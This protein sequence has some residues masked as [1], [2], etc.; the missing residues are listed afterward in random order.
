MLE[1]DFTTIIFQVINFLAL[2]IAL[3]F[4]LFRKIIHRAKVR[5]QELEMIQKSTMDD[6]QNAEKLKMD[7]EL[8]IQNIDARIEESFDKA[9][10]DLEEIRNKVLNDAKEQAEQ[11][12]RQSFESLRMTQ[13]QSKEDFR[14]EIVES[15]ILISKNLLKKISSEE[16]HT[17]LIKEINDRILDLGRKEM[18]RVAVIRESLSERE[19]ILFIETAMP[20][21]KDHQAGIIR[22]FSALADRNVKLD[23]KQVENLICGVRIRLGDY[24]FDNSLLSKLEE[25]GNSTIKELSNSSEI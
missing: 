23:I 5:K 22:N 2:V 15:A 12:L 3:Y 14:S 7:L 24:I 18:S 19:P 6:L 11:I 25:I 20:L 10:S 1:I 9:K 4:L 17:F 21:H 8:E 13:E 16:L